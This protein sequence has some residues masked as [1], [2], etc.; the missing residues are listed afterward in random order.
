MIIKDYEVCSPDMVSGGT[1]LKGYKITTYSRLCEVLGPPTFTSANPDDKVSCEWVLDTQWYDANCIEEIDRDDWEYDTVTIYAWKYG[2]IPTEE[3]QW[4]IGGKSYN[5]TEIIDM[6]VD[7]YNQ[8]GENWNGER[9]Y[10]YDA[11]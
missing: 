1:S 2:Y 3:C 4:N 5:A 7:N 8:N 6:I 10:D 9:N 11:A